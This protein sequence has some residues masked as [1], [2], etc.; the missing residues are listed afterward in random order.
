[1][2]VLDVGQGQCILLQTGGQTYV[3]DCG[4]SEGEGAGRKRPATSWPRERP[5]WTV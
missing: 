2:T 3:V 5:G 1:M 4:G